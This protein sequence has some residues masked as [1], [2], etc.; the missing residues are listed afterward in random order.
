MDVEDNFESMVIRTT[1]HF[2]VNVGQVSRA[3]STSMKSRVLGTIIS[4]ARDFLVVHVNSP[5]V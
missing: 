1:Q 3:T 4:V 5:G 2:W